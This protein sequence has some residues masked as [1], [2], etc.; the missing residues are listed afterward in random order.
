M[1]PHTSP[2]RRLIETA[3]GHSPADLVIRD[4]T[5]LDVYGGRLVPHRSVAVVD[6]WIAYVGPDASHTIG[7][8]TKVID[9]ANRILAP[10]YMDTHTHLGN[11]WD[12]SEFLRY[13]IPGGATTYITEAESF[14]YARG[15]EGVR[16][17]LSQSQGRPVKF[18][19]LVPP[20]VTLSPTDKSNAI[21]PGELRELLRDDRVI[22]LG[23]SYWQDVVPT[24]DNRVLE[25]MQETLRAGK[26]VQGHAAGAFDRKLAA[27]A[28]AGALSCHEAISTEDVLSRLEMGY[29]VMVREGDIR[30][31]LEILLPLKDAMDLRRV[32]L[33]TDGTNPD[34]LLKQ[35]YLVD[36]IQKA[37]DLGLDPVKAVQMVTLNPAEHFGISHFCGGIAPNRFADI[38]LLPDEKHMKPDLVLSEGRIVAEGGRVTVPLPRVPYPEAFFHT[39]KIPPFSQA[40][41]KVPVG[42]A[43]S[44]DSVRTLE[45]QPGGLVAREGRA[46][47]RIV[48]GCLEADPQNDFLKAVFIE[49]LSGRGEF[50]IGF[51]RGWG[52]KEGAAATTLCWETMGIVAV[53]TNDLDLSVAINKV[54]GMQGGTV[55]AAGGN[56]RSAIP[57]NVGGFLSELPMEAIAAGLNAFQREMVLLGS[58]FEHA[59]MALMVLTTSAIPFIRMTEKGYYRF[60]ENDYVGL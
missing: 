51:V 44:P 6:R 28:A 5:L 10:G 30:R 60:R 54:I 16:V 27:Y 24:A 7:G 56:I 4:G 36:V 1:V 45:I 48:D 12:L 34:L 37:V 26:S 53:G 57:F 15:A 32:I 25:L 29:H 38:L 22:G 49:R 55:L 17:F 59:H 50:F 13:A 23:E 46:R 9:A 19:C 35:G 20:L 31:D 39:V 47:P 40:Q 52:Q 2:N 41:L 33:V 58:P 3:L 21:S 43:S 18:F 42:A 14:G 8:H 11:Y